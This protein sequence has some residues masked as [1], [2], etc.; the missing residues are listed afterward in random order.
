MLPLFV[1][2]GSVN[3]TLKRFEDVGRNDAAVAKDKVMFQGNSKICQDRLGLELMLLDD[4][5]EDHEDVGLVAAGHERFKMLHTLLELINCPVFSSFVR[6]HDRMD[7]PDRV[8][9]VGDHAELDLIVAY[10]AS[11]S[12]SRSANHRQ[13]ETTIVQVLEVDCFGHALAY[14]NGFF[15]FKALKPINAARRL[16]KDSFHIVK[17]KEMAKSHLLPLK[18]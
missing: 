18:G 10:A 7:L 9:H 8:Y 5:R 6:P 14:S 17:T 4:V 13:P 2:L 12:I 1:F 16:F 11:I 15:C 3:A